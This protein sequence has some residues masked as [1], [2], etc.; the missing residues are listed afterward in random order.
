MRAVMTFPSTTPTLAPIDSS[1]SMTVLAYSVLI[2]HSTR[3][4]PCLLLETTFEKRLPAGGG[5]FAIIRN[6][7]STLV[8]VCNGVIPIREKNRKKRA[9][10][11][12]YDCT[13]FYKKS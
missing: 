12:K 3:S 7:G 2:K 8:W 13:D 1:F 5:L 11:I 4:S 10:R 9:K 6:S